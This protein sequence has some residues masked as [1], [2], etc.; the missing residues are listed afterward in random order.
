MR[1]TRLYLFGFVALGLID[2]AIGPSL[3]PL[4]RSFGVDLAAVASALVAM[5]VGR[6]LGSA[7][8][9]RLYALPAPHRTLALG[10][11]FSALMALA[12]TLTQSVPGMLVVGFGLGIVSSTVDVGSNTLI[13]WAHGERVGP[14]MNALH[15]AFGIGGA[16]APPTV[17]MSLQAVSGVQFAWAVVAALCLLTAL[18]ALRTPAPPPSAAQ[19]QGTKN[20]ISPLVLLPLGVTFFL[21]VGAEASL[22]TWLTDYGVLMGMD[23]VGAA[24]ALATGFW[25]TYIVGRL[26]AIALTRRIAPLRVALGGLVLG[27]LAAILFVLSSAHAEGGNA[28]LWVAVLAMGLGFGPVFPNAVSVAGAR[29]GATSGLT[30][31][32]FVVAGAGATFWPW[33]VGQRIDATAGGVVP[34]VAAACMAGSFVGF[35]AFL[36][37]TRQRV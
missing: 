7:L 16:L 30:S 9:G 2:A 23:R 29:L 33:W 17:A 1:Q 32:L 15:V 14:Y 5:A 35:S 11:A 25:V 27:A 6:L 18:A 22:V 34:W 4:A 20:K 3:G 19:A 21:Y 28:P 10:F 36:L 37:R 31:F 8:S 24:T 12:I 26:T 13:Q